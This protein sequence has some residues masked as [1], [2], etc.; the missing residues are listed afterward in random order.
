[1][2]PPDT[3]FTLI[4]STESK[5][6]DEE[7]GDIVDISGLEERAPS[8][9]P[10]GEI[11]KEKDIFNILLLGTDE[12]TYDFSDAARSDAIMILSLNLKDS[13]AKLAALSEA[14]AFPFSKASMKGST[15][16]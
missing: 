7:E 9:L 13:T 4:S 5:E 3:T 12:R 11:R 6:A 10:A 14:W 16:G 8:E 1:M 2:T 15:T